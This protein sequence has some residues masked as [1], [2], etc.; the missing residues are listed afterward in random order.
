M[1]KS[2]PVAAA[3]PMDPVGGPAARAPFV[4]PAAEIRNVLEARD[5]SVFHT[6]REASVIAILAFTPEPCHPP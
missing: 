3:A 2:A 5:P 6:Q 1:E 4:E